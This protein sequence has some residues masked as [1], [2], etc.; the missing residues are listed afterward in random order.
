[1]LDREI[2]IKKNNYK[3]NNCGYDRKHFLVVVRSLSR[4]VWMFGYSDLTCS[5]SSW[6]STN[7][8]NPFSTVT[9]VVH[10]F[11]NLFSVMTRNFKDIVAFAVQS[12]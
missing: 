12:S 11:Q 1:M 4:V 9:S 7:S 6:I 2:N 8:L 5:H 3:I 10:P